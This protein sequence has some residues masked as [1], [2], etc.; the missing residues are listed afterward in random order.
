MVKAGV[1]FMGTNAPSS[2]ITNVSGLALLILAG[3]PEESNEDRLGEHLDQFVGLASRLIDRERALRM[4][5][6]MEIALGV[7]KA[8]YGNTNPF[9]QYF[10][11]ERIATP[12][13]RS[14]VREH[15]LPSGEAS[16]WLAGWK[17]TLE[18]PFDGYTPLAPPA[19]LNWRTLESTVRVV[20][21]TLKAWINVAFRQSV[22]WEDFLQSLYEE[23]CVKMLGGGAG[24][25]NEEAGKGLVVWEVKMFWE[26]I[27]AVTL[28]ANKLGYHLKCPSA[29]RLEVLLKKTS[30]GV[31]TYENIEW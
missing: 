31:P 4:Q 18:D 26:Y 24:R 25:A 7:L 3:L 9:A 29:S 21:S 30:Q 14:L 20:D 2:D 23:H 12:E 16:P 13:L 17:K 8:R 15:T 22:A 28:N 6:K 27:D 1:R 10:P 19:D 11:C 5:P